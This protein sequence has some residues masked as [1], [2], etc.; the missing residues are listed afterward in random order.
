MLDGRRIIQYTKCLQKYKSRTKGSVV[1]ISSEFAA[2]YAIWVLRAKIQKTLTIAKI[3]GEKW[4]SVI[5][6]QDKRVVFDR[7]RDTYNWLSVPVSKAGVFHKYR[8]LLGLSNIRWWEN[9]VTTWFPQVFANFGCKF[10]TFYF[11]RFRGKPFIFK[12]DIALIDHLVK[13]LLDAVHQ[14]SPQLIDNRD[15][16]L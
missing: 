16:L 11:K 15:S 13:R 12:D 3:Y 2:I 14:T 9:F 1:A 10:M 8:L 4:K 6:S 5:F 7:S